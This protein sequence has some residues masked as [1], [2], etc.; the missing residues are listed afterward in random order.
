MSLF[1]RTKG[2]E[3]IKPEDTLK[4]F[5]ENKDNPSYVALDVRSI[6]E[7]NQGHIE[8]A[9]LLNVNSNDFED[10]LAKMDKN[11][12][13]FVYCKAGHRSK[14]AANLMLKNGFKNVYNV[15]GGFDKWKSKNLPFEK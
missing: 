6:E 15:L 12:T 11:K 13:Y 14:K 8:N 5:E 9:E 2:Y 10:G 4:L 7:Y 1:K 3:D